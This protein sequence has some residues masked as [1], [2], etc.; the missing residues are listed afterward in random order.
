MVAWHIMEEELVQEVHKNTG[1]QR[2]SLD[3][4]R[5]AMSVHMQVCV[6]VPV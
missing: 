6:Y 2:G 5:L 4:N 1:S 3:S